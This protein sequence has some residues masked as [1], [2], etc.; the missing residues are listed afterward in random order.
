MSHVIR[1]NNKKNQRIRSDVKLVSISMFELG[2]DVFKSKKN[3]PNWN[4]LN[5]PGGI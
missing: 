3:Q 5:T 1:V 2:Y 4:N